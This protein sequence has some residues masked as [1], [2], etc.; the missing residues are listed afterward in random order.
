MVYAQGSL[1]SQ[2]TVVVAKSAI[3]SLL[4]KKKKVGENDN[5]CQKRGVE[6]QVITRRVTGLQLISQER[7]GTCP[8]VS[9]PSLLVAY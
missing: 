5:L 3:I 6:L 4:S 8:N 9:Y 2:Y 7:D 1:Y